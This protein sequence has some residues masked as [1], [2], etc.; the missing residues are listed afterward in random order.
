MNHVWM[1]TLHSSAA[2]QKLVKERQLQIKGKLCLVIDPDTSDVSLKLH[3]VPFYVPD[4]FVRRAL[5][6]YGKVLEVARDKV[7]SGFFAGI[8]TK[9]RLVRMTLKDGVTKESLPHQLKM[10]GANALVLVPGRAPLCL[11]CKKTG[12]I[13]ED[14]RAPRCLKCNR[15][16]TKP[17]TV[18]ARMR[19]S[20]TRRYRKKLATTSWKLMK[21]RQPMAPTLLVLQ[22]TL[23]H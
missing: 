7:R 16:G 13:R 5:E 8:E 15:Y 19:Q 11:R 3:W 4:E 1:L 14:C 6:P 2:K 9:T 17:P 20:L 18:C 12:H 10:P 23:C 22:L 21:Q